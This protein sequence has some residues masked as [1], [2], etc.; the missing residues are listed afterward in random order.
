MTASN[1]DAATTPT[2]TQP[3]T[4][5]IHHLGLTVPDVA[6]SRFFVDALGFQKVAERPEYPA[7]FVSDGSVMLTLWQAE[8]PQRAVPFDRRKNIGL[9]HF[10]LRVADAGALAATHSRTHARLAQSGCS[11]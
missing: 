8:E 9:H 3:C 2:P 7:I 11:M 6:A 1:S 5:G 10:A 4:S